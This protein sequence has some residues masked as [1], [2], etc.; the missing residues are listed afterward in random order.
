MISMGWLLSAEKSEG[1]WP[2]TVASSLGRVGLAAVIASLLIVQSGCAGS[3]S[4]G[5]GSRAELYDSIDGL[6]SDSTA[7]VIGT[8]TDQSTDG[9]ATVSSLEVAIAPASPQLG[10]TAPDAE[11]VKVG[12]TVAVRQDPA[13]RPL[14]ETGRTYVLW[15]TP[16]M[17]DGAAA[18]QFFITGSNAGMYILDGAVARRV[19][20]E[21]GDTLP[22]TITVGDE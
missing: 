4:E 21:T 16:T 1:T 19:A 17:L 2:V 12:D 22:E 20:M 11:A 5:A 6:A 14:L 10:A 15:L 13:S 3:A 18:T 7:I 9:G 8:V